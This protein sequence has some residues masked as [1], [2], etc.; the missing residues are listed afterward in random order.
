V[1][2]TIKDDRGKHFDPVLVDCFFEILDVIHSIAN[3]YPDK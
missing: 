2:Q 1:L 3:R